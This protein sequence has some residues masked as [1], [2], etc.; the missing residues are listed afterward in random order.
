M[1]NG[2][3][4]LQTVANPVENTMENERFELKT[5]AHTVEM[6]VSSSKML[7][8]AWKMVR[9]GNQKKKTN[10]KKKTNNFLPFHFMHF[11]PHQFASSNRSS[12]MIRVQPLPFARNG[13]RTLGL[14][15]VGAAISYISTWMKWT[16]RPWRRQV[17]SPYGRF[18]FLK[19]GSLPR[20]WL[21][22]SIPWFHVCCIS[23]AAWLDME[24]GRTCWGQPSTSFRKSIF[25]TSR[26]SND[27][28]STSASSLA[29]CPVSSLRQETQVSHILNLAFMFR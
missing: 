23:A 15:A 17:F 22:Q 14:P 27:S 3:N 2:Q 20:K 5:V 29:S 13:G 7:Q 26:V 21:Y 24:I 12:I 4:M 9:T 11:D 1:E 25:C 28:F 19:N 10:L 18:M 8:I 16:W 6:A